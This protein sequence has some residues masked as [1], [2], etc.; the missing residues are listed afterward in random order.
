MLGQVDDVL[1]EAHHGVGV[2]ER[3]VD[4]AAQRRRRCG[5][6]P[7][8]RCPSDA[9]AWNPPETRKRSSRAAEYAPAGKPSRSPSGA[10]ADVVERHRAGLRGPHA[11]GVPVVGE[12][13]ARAPSTAR[14]RSRSAPP[15]RR[16]R[17][18]TATLID[19]RRRR[20]RG[21][22]LA[23]VDAPAAVDPLGRRRRAGQVLRRRLADR[24]GEDDIGGR[25]PSA[26]SPRNASAWRVVAAGDGD[27]PPAH[28]VEQHGEVHV[29]ADRRR[30][31]AAGEP[32]HGDE[33]VVDRAHAAAAE[34]ARDRR[35]RG[36]PRRAAGRGAR[37][38]TWRHGRGRARRRRTR[39]RTPRRWPPS[40]A[41]RGVGAQL[42]DARST[43]RSGHA[44]SWTWIMGGSSVGAGGSGCEV[45]GCGYVAATATVRRRSEATVGSGRGG[46]AGRG[47]TSAGAAQVGAAAPAASPRPRRARARWVQLYMLA[48]RTPR[49]SAVRAAASS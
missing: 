39:R 9:A 18:V 10:D 32:R 5:R 17:Y 34:L 1:G 36:S 8:R 22:D 49:R 16:R 37:W 3:G 41:G 19:R 38:R 15:R 11:E 14:G 13:D 30:G 20:H 26:A 48:S 45:I 44:G 28:D 6:A 25:R 27:A 4:P 43:G 21:E 7:T 31:V 42:A 33:H 12:L 24:G 29:D 40:R 35:V 2:V 23:A 47:A 46:E